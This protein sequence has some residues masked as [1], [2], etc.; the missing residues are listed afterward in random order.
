LGI[1][2]STCRLSGRKGNSSFKPR[3][4]WV[5]EAMEMIKSTEKTRKRF[6]RV[7]IRKRSGYAMGVLHIVYPPLIMYACVYP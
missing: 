2:V 4:V 6:K 1:V 7:F 5:M 3:M